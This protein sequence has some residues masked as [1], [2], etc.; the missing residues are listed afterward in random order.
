MTPMIIN[1][2]LAHAASE[3][4]ASQWTDYD[5]SFPSPRGRGIKGEGP[6]G[7][8]AIFSLQP[9]QSN[10]P[11]TMKHLRIHNNRPCPPTNI[12]DLSPLPQ[13]EDS[14]VWKKR[15]ED[16]RENE[17][18][19]YRK[20]LAVIDRA[21][22]RI[23]ARPFDPVTIDELVK[24]IEVGFALGRRAVGLPE[25]SN[26]FPG[27]SSHAAFMREVDQTL[28]KI[29]GGRDAAETDCKVTGSVSVAGRDAAPSASASLAHRNNSPSG[30]SHPPPAAND[31]NPPVAPKSD[32]GGAT[33]QPPGARTEVPRTAATG[34]ENPPVDGARTEVPRPAKHKPYWLNGHYYPNPEYP[35]A[36][37]R[38]M[39]TNSHQ[40]SQ[41]R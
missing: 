15:A 11:S 28:A 26:D 34:T 4:R 1:M 20:S 14:A 18:L 23:L 29:Y 33:N 6:T 35:E 39:F 25:A 32:E 8:P 36:V 5:R 21:L 10:Y 38:A 3:S 16:V 24:L 31:Q 30:L 40:T 41:R 12:V 9:I 13:L 2:H 22:D 19:L 17:W 7:S 37:A 27:S